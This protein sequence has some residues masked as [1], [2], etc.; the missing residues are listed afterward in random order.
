[1][2]LRI[3]Y[4]METLVTNRIKVSNSV[5]MSQHQIL[6]L[7]KISVTENAQAYFI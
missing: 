5:V 2:L 3:T 1:M 6:D 7:A 4:A